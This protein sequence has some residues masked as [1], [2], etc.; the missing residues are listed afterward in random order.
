[1]TNQEL[2]LFTIAGKRAPIYVLPDLPPF[3]LDADL[4]II[5][6]TTTRNIT[7]AVQRRLTRFPQRYS[8]VLSQDQLDALRFQNGTANPVSSMSRSLPRAFS[9][10]GANMLS[11]VLTGTVADEV[12][13]AINDAFTEMERRAFADVKF[14]LEKLRQDATCNKPI[15]MRVMRAAQEGWDFEQLFQSTNYTRKRLDAAVKELVGMGILSEPLAGMQ[16]DLF[17]HV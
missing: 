5:Y 9:H 6:G 4:A 13:V 16:R 17:A 7:K 2:T 8:W 10:G 12:A 11:G 14:M 15:Y 3:M 1:M